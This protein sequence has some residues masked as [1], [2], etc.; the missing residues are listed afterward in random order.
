MARVSILGAGSWGIALATSLLENRHQIK[1]WEF[2]QSAAARLDQSREEPDKLPGIKLSPEIVVTDNLLKAVE[3]AELLLLVVPAQVMRQVVEQLK[4]TGCEPEAIVACAKGIE[5][6][7]LQ[8]M[9]EVIGEVLGQEVLPRVT[10]LSGPSHAEEV[11]R[12]Q[13]T[14]VVAA[15]SN[16]DVV[17]RV[18][19]IMSTTTFRVYGSD[20]LAGV[21]LGGSLKNV[22]AV[23]AGIIHGLELGD[24]TLGALLTRGLAEMSRLG[25]RMG[26]KAETFAGLSGLGD[27]VTTAASRHSRNRLVGERI[28]RGEKL[29]DILESMKMV[30][31]GVETTRAA[32]KLAERYDVEM[33]ITTQVHEV[34]FNDKPP[35][36]AIGNLMSRQLK[37]EVY[38]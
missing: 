37:R 21:E 14:S 29:S 25:T 10:S 38:Y 32:V 5:V 30:A 19:Q 1:L 23:A 27:L 24:N 31:E 36:E 3:N 13:P 18:Q 33:P 12:N 11:A 4:T 34:L 17:E 9:S 8:R 6:G 7:S 22:I 15:G 2:D 20:D 26:A 28:G 16:L 35:L